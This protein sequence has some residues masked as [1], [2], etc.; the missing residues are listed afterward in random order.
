ML[1]AFVLL[2]SAL[3][4]TVSMLSAIRLTQSQQPT[5]ASADLYKACSGF[6]FY[7]DDSCADGKC[8]QSGL[9]TKAYVEWRQQFLA[10][11]K[12]SEGMF[13]ERI[14]IVNVELN[15][16][17]LRVFWRIEYVFVLDWVRA[18]LVNVADL[19]EYPLRQEP[20]EEAISRAIKI[21]L[22][23]K[24]ELAM[25]GV[26]PRSKVEQALRSCDARMQ[27]DWCSI[28]FAHW[29]GKL[30]V[31]G[32]STVDDGENRCRSAAID[33]ATGEVVFCRDDPCRIH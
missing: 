17:P 13:R 19:G 24:D 7:P 2:L 21:E 27:A 9:A 26:A 30:L 12:M 28:R 23:E 3:V 10:K 6:T 33:V 14:K 18:R 31:G 5:V 15:E 11:Y 22:F 8:A 20:S 1:T 32:R 4:S 16:G 25:E 29:N